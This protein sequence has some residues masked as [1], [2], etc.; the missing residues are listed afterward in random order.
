MCRDNSFGHEQIL[1]VYSCFLN[2]Y[3]HYCIDH[4]GILCVYEHYWYVFLKFH[5]VWIVNFPQSWQSNFI[6]LW[7]LFS[8]TFKPF[9]VARLESQIEHLYCFLLELASPATSVSDDEN[10]SDMHLYCCIDVILL[11]ND[12]TWLDYSV[13]EYNPKWKIWFLRHPLCPV[14]MMYDIL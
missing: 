4:I 5:S 7:I 11:I 6:P 8:W 1:Y 12:S 9:F 10:S 2:L 3:I 13:A 14:N